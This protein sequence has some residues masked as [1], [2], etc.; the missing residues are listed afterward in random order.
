MN[1]DRVNSELK[2]QIALMIDNSEIKD[3]RL[4]GMISVTGL[5][6]SKDLAYATVYISV[7]GGDIKDTLAVLKNASGH[8]RNTLKSRVKIRNMPELRFVRDDS[9]EYGLKMDKLIDG[10]IGKD[11]E[12]NN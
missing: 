1:L 12:N 10:V 7:L 11:N 6:T 2:R 4:Q 8:I 9:I 5:N 3:P